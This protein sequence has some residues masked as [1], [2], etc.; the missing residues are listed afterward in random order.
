LVEVSFIPP[1]TLSLKKIKKGIN[2]HCPLYT[3]SNHQSK[4]QT[5]PQAKV[6]TSA[7]SSKLDKCANLISP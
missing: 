5:K 6:K 2:R 7:Q 3:V 4:E 1:Q